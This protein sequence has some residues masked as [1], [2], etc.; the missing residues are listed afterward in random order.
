MTDR[1]SIEATVHLTIL[2][3]QIVLTMDEAKELKAKLDQIVPETRV[4]LM[5]NPLTYENLKEQFNL[6]KGL[7]KFG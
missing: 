2:D 4:D 1:I 3:K 6:G 7:N 5:Q